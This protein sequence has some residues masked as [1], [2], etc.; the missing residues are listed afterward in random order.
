MKSVRDRFFR[1]DDVR[2]DVVAVS[3]MDARLCADC[4]AIFAHST[5]CPACAGRS[6]QSVAR[7]LHRP[8]TRA[9]RVEQR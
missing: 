7:A 2:L 8:P 9:E 3:L 6:W 1:S 5:T 4:E